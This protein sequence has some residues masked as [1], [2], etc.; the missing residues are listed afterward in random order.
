MSKDGSVMVKNETYQAIG[1]R[2]EIKVNLESMTRCPGS[3]QGCFISADER[4]NGKFWGADKFSDA[5]KFVARF[6]DIHRADLDSADEFEVAINL[7]QGDHLDV[8]DD[9]ILPAASFIESVYEGRATAF[10]TASAVSSEKRLAHTARQWVSAMKGKSLVFFADLVFDPVMSNKANFG[11]RYHRN[12]QVLRDTIGEVDL[13][14]NVGPDT[15]SAISPEQLHNFVC[16]HQFG[17]LTLNFAPT[18][19]SQN[20]FIDQSP[21]IIS[22]IKKLIHTWSPPGTTETPQYLL[23]TFATLF[24]PIVA[25]RYNK[26]KGIHIDDHWLIE[27]ISNHL[28]RMIYIDN[29]GDVSFI[30]SGIGDLPIGKRIG[31]RTIGN[32]RDLAEDQN[33]ESKIKDGARALAVN[34][35]TSMNHSLICKTCSHRFVCA[36]T[37]GYFVNKITREKEDCRSGLQDLYALI[38]EYESHF[39]DAACA[40]NTGKIMSAA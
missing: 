38:D 15:L 34:I 13:N 7:V 29:H 18:V 20:S 2:F 12:I 32:M 9:A 3:C 25:H 27:S 26:T 36:V 35:V 33:L 8:S 28:S 1:S 37:G 11:A 5:Q 22:W 39:L 23:N 24:R 16:T 30:Q 6:V 10:I 17:I 21:K 4:K 40:S 14:I 19:F 31:R